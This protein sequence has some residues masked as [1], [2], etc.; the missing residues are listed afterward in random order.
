MNGGVKIL[1]TFNGLTI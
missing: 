1:T